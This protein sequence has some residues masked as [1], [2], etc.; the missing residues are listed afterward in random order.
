MQWGQGERRRGHGA[1]VRRADGRTTGGIDAVRGQGRYAHARAGVGCDART[2][3]LV[4]GLLARREHQDEVDPAGLEVRGQ[5]EG[6]DPADHCTWPC[7]RLC[8]PGRRRWVLRARVTQQSGSAGARLEAARSRT[9]DS[10][11]ATK[12]TRLLAARQ[13]LRRSGAPSQVQLC[14][15]LQQRGGSGVCSERREDALSARTGSHGS[16]ANAKRAVEGSV[17]TP[18]TA[19]RE[20]WGHTDMS[21]ICIRS[22]GAFLRVC[23]LRAG[24]ISC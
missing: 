11:G 4:L 15:L 8:W 16:A 5:G 19:S 22:A 13:H 17:L 20:G 21:Y 24:V 6:P 7:A 23:F 10:P 18:T 9:L 1:S 12:R 3:R 14:G 2:S